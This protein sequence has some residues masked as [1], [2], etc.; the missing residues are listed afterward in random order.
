MGPAAIKNRMSEE[1]VRGQWK[2]LRGRIKEWWGKLTDDDVKR[3][4]GSHDKLVGLL[5]QRYGYA[6]DRALTEVSRRIDEFL[7]KAKGKP[8]Q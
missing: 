1:I 3:I 6:K 2:E 7:A 8:A 5:Q 4:D